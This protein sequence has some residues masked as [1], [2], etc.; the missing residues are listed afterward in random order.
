M[1]T[2][3]PPGVAKPVLALAGASASGG[4]QA[5]DAAYR[6]IAWRLLPLLFVCYIAAYLDRV[7]VGF[8]KLQMKAALQ[9]SDSVYGLGAGIFFLGYFI[10]E[11]PSN[12]AL[13]RVGA[14]RWIARIMV[15]WGLLSMA[16]MLVT[17]PLSFYLLRFFLGAAEAGFFPGV[18]LYLTYWFPAQRRSKALAF[19]LSAIPFAGI[20]GGPSSGWI[21]QRLEGAHGLQ[22]WQWLFL[23]QGLPSVLLALVVWR[24]LDDRVQDACWLSDAQRRIVAADLA[25]DARGKLGGGL[26]QVIR[27]PQVWLLA[28]VYFTLVAGIYCVSFWLPT[29][30]QAA[31]VTQA[32]H[33]GLLS[34][35]PWAFGLVSMAAAARSADWHGEYRRHCAAGALL[36]ALGLAF[37]AAFDGAVAPAL[38]GLTVGTMGIMAAL[39][40]FWGLPTGLLGGGAAAAGIALVNS[41]GNLSGFCAPFVV[42]LLKQHVDG[43]GTGAGV[44]LF[45]GLLLAGAVAVLRVRRPQGRP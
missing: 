14:R 4:S 31:G 40:V 44:F 11:I 22:G 30:L 12:T 27:L 43:A 41:F 34:V 39:P 10:F 26:R 23:L 7:N 37:S 33:I 32:F 29:I 1:K 19:F 2:I 25:R 36:G 28:L 3:I 5:A 15:T 6:K 9:F 24:V 13:H 21:L 35:L 17:T 42:G 18:V 16:T 8:A 45:A 38:F 20:L